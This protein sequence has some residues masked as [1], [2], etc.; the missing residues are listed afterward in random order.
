VRLGGLAV[1]AL[2][3]FDAGAQAQQLD[4]GRISRGGDEQLSWRWRGSDNRDYSAAFTLTKDAIGE[5]EASFREFSMEDMWRS[6]EAELRD[7]VEKFGQRTSIKLSRNLDGLH[8]TISGPDQRLVDQL[9]RQVAERL[10]RTQK[11]YL[12]RYT[13]RRVDQR[14]M[15]DFAAA[16]R[17]QQRPMRA[18]ARAL[19]A[20]PGVADNDRARMTLALGFFQQI[21]YATLDDK[22]RRGGDF[23]P[24][25][26]LLAQNRGDCDSKVVA[27][28][29]VLRTYTPLRKLVVVTMPGHAILATDLPSDAEDWAVRAD[30][31][32]YVALEAAGPAMATVGQVSS[33]TAK[34][35][36]EGRAIEIWPLN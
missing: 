10:E 4:F 6:L 23:L 22:R 18:A 28:A 16:T 36:K 35:L 9:S 3:V 15:V 13:R 5:A 32:Q 17:A 20:T 21:P 2:L 34:Y 14:I 25:P 30:G 26:A 31:R 12:A 33:L 27:L 11:A 29:A 1:A 8:W 19:G 24:A 7:E